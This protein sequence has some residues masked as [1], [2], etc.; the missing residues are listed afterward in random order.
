MRTKENCL[1]RI[2][3]HVKGKDKKSKVDD[4]ERQEDHPMMLVT[5]NENG[6][7]FSGILVYTDKDGK[8]RVKIGIEDEQ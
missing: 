3:E 5:C 6:C 1:K 2:Y 7:H 8:I 4:I